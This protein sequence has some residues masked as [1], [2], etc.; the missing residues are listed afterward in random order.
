[1]APAYLMND[2]AAPHPGACGLS[3]QYDWWPDLRFVVQVKTRD[4]GSVS[5]KG[6]VCKE[7]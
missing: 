7:L 3:V 5:G 6:A 2:G 1:M 4:M